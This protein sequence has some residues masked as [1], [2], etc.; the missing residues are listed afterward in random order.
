MISNRAKRNLVILFFV[1][2]AAI[3]FVIAGIRSYEKNHPANV[4]EEMYFYH[5]DNEVMPSYRIITDLGSKWLEN[6]KGE[7]FFKTTYVGDL[8]EGE[9]V[10][11]RWYKSPKK[12]VFVH[13]INSHEHQYTYTFDDQSL[14]Y[15]K[16][17]SVNPDPFL[18]DIVLSEWFI[19][20]EGKSSFSIENPG[21]FIRIPN[22]EEA[23]K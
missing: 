7:S 8:P 11:I 19:C 6:S 15:S 10:V 21:D 1:I 2:I 23:L 12:I 17:Y 9:S 5:M 4:F 13:T 22:T 20:R 18:Y 3:I 16:L 14:R